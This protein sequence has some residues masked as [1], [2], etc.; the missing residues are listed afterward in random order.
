MNRSQFCFP[1]VVAG[2]LLL[3]LVGINAST[4]INADNLGVYSGLS[5]LVYLA[6]GVPMAVVA[7]DLIYGISS[8]R[9]N[10]FLIL[11]SQVLMLVLGFMTGGVGASSSNA[12]GAINYFG[13]IQYSIHYG[14][15][16]VIPLSAQVGQW[17]G[18]TSF[19]TVMF[20]AI[21]LTGQ[22]Q[23]TLAVIASRVGFGL[24]DT[25]VIYLV[26][27]SLKPEDHYAPSFA[28]LLFIGC[29]YFVPIWLQDTAFAYSLFLFL[30]LYLVLSKKESYLV[31]VLG[32]ASLVMSNFYAS[33]TLGGLVFAHFV[34]K[35]DSTLVLVYLVLIL[36]WNVIGLPF[37]YSASVG[38]YFITHLFDYTFLFN[39]VTL[40]LS[41]GSSY[42]HLIALTQTGL[43]IMLSGMG[44]AAF[45]IVRIRGLKIRRIADM[46]LVFSILIALFGVLGAPGFGLNPIEGLERAFIAITPFLVVLSTI[47]GGRKNT[48]FYLIIMIAI[49]PVAVITTYGGAVP[50]YFS[51]S[52][53][54]ASVYLQSHWENNT[55][56]AISSPVPYGPTGGGIFIFTNGSVILSYSRLELNYTEILNISPDQTKPV[57]G[58][59]SH[60]LQVD[61]T[62]LNGSD[63]AYLK[64][65]AKVLNTDPVVYSNPDTKY[66]VA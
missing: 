23:V 64:F 8:E 19:F 42:H 35:R 46:M 11:L 63:G 29:D 14:L 49:L 17:P 33:I 20:S 56:V 3:Y 5:P 61:A 58:S 22:S 66:Y 32:F 7:I 45:V 21:G 28:A 25:F 41:Q 34:L 57:I 53:L 60:T 51:S 6:I 26:A 24:F 54:S 30:A 12:D 4:Y 36:A 37:L 16:K 18:A 39:R 43:M 48:L 59:L 31:I 52:A 55:V 50:T 13:V 1:V 47:L 65:A 38:A 10:L 27:R 9:Q 62:I 44:L 2:S 15:Q 40:A